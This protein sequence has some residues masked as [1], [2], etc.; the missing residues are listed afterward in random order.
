MGLLANR[1]GGKGFGP[2]TF[3]PEIATFPFVIPSEA[4]GSAVPLTFPGNVF[5]DRG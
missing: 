4:E 1:C 5:S 3:F 2:A